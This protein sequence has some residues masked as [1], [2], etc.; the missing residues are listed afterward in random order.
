M[1][2]TQVLDLLFKRRWRRLKVGNDGEDWPRC[3]TFQRL[4]MND[5]RAFREFYPVLSLS[6]NINVNVEK[7]YW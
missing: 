6:S 4:N 5:C 3:S 7:C 1:R 2:K